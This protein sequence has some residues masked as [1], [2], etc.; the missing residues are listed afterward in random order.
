[1]ILATTNV[2]KSIT[3]QENR[4]PEGLLHGTVVEPN[5]EDLSGFHLIFST[6]LKSGNTELSIALDDKC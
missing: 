1:M 4:T 2:R 6:G 3:K 5:P